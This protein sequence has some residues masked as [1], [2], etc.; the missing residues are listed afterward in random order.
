[1][2]KGRKTTLQER[3]EIVQYTIANE[4]N[5]HEAAKK[6]NVSYQQVYSWLR[7]YEKDGKQGLQD[8]RGKTLETKA[9]FTEEEKLQLRIKELEH[10]NQ[11]LEAENGLLK[12]LALR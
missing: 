6:Y 12:K 10:R 1:M 5:Y 4:R 2:T 8:R 9:S 7:K 3:I 11:Y